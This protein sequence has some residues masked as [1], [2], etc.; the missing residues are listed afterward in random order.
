MQAHALIGFGAGT[1]AATALGSAAKNGLSGS[2]RA[3]KTASFNAGGLAGSSNKVS[4]A[5]KEL[6]LGSIG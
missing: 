3:E 6:K 4:T 1:A 2:N 5:A